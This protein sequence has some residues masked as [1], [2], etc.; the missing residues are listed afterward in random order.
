MSVKSGSCILTEGEPT[1]KNPV[2]YV[3][4]GGLEVF[5]YPVVPSFEQWYE[6]EYP[7]SPPFGKLRESAKRR[8][9]AYYELKLRQGDFTLLRDRALQILDRMS[10]PYGD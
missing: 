4:E 6:Q 5:A 1:T 10:N 2:S 7:D 8:H 9:R 3:Q